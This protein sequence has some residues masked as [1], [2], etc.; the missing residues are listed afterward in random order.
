MRTVSK[1]VALVMFWGLLLNYGSPAA[2]A[3]GETLWADFKNRFVTLDGRV[4]DRTNG[5]I[6][7]SEGQGYGMLLATAFNDRPTFVRLWS[8]TQTYLMIREDGLL[9]WKWEPDGETHYPDTNSASDGDI[10]VAYALLRAAERWD[11]PAYGKAARELIQTIRR[12]LVTEVGGYTIV[13]PGPEGFRRPNGVIVNLSYWVFPALQEFG[14]ITSNSV[15]DA[16]V[17]SGLRLLDEA[18]FGEWKLPPD[19]L[20]LSDQGS[21]QIA[22]HSEFSPRFGYNAMRIPLYLIWGGKTDAKILENIK[23]FWSQGDE[24]RWPVVADLAAD[25]VR[26]RTKDAGV[27]A[28]LSLI[29][30]LDGNKGPTAGLKGQQEPRY[31]EMVLALLTHVARREVDAEC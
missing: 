16:L 3:D 1:L 29:A 9:A 7:H 5:G 24:D 27:A 19:W 10:L 13:L 11:K 28:Q 2:E 6:S 26:Q 12:E 15:W 17:Q 30:C 23:T 20:Y 4:V 21:V 8:W 18:Q 22:N 25:K 14:E 31:Y